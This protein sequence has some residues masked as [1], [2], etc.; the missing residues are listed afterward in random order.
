MPS[1]HS[2][3]TRTQSFAYRATHSN[4]PPLAGY[5]LHLISIK[6]SNLCVS[7]DVTSTAALLRLA[8]DVG[9]SI[10]LIKTHADIINDFGDKT[11]RGLREIAQRKKFLVFEDRKFGDIGSTVQKQ[12]TAGPLEIVR[13]AC[14]TN[15]HIFPGPAIVRALKEAAAA[16]IAQLN[17][18]VQTEISAG[19]PRTSN[20]SARSTS[21]ADYMSSPRKGS[22]VAATTIETR[23]ESLSSPEPMEVGPGAEA[24]KEALDS[25]G[26]IPL[27]R[28]LLLLAEMSSEG[29]LLTGAYTERCVEIAREHKDFVI[30][31]IAQHGL[32]S[33]P[34]DSFITF[35]P[36]VS[37]P[38]VSGIE[39]K[40][41]GLGQQYNTPRK[42]IREEGGD[43]IIVG[44]GIIDA[45][46]KAAEAERYRK[47]AWA[48][49]EKRI[50][51]RKN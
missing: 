41:D 37:L 32:N 46:D 44:R 31:F 50:G 25:L 51:A 39:R 16:S 1:S 15:A 7:A 45:T 14:I 24:Q 4:I 8:E 42:V 38:P 43:V 17:Q 49:Y 22:I 11:I 3:H 26:D 35:T 10:C 33:K 5:L 18:S 47:E 48:A 21:E 19:T 34:D 29:N 13:W 23:T 6:R 9:D 20:D 2:H 12:Y 36:G 27:A 28:G 30:G 40:G